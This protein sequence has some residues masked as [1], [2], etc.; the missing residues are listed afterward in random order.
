MRPMNESTV[1]GAFQKLCREMLPGCVLIKHADK[2]M[3]GV[4]DASLTHNGRTVW[5]EYKFIGPKTKG[6]TAQFM[7][8][9]VWSPEDVAAASPTQYDM[10][11]RLAVA[12]HALY[13]FWVLD[14]KARRK[15]VAHIITWHSI[16]KERN[17]FAGNNW[18]VTYLRNMV[19][20]QWRKQ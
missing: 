18:V 13:I 11:K 9:G 17:R 10:V 15:K 14:P 20:L 1:S 19:N 4:P 16:T 7:L 6:V 2:S 12:G 5:L 8:D 3:I